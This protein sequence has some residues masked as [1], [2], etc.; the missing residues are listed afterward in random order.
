MDDTWRANL[1]F[2]GLWCVYCDCGIDATTAEGVREMKHY[3]RAVCPE[4]T[5]MIEQTARIGVR[6]VEYDAATGRFFLSLRNRTYATRHEVPEHVA[7]RHFTF[8]LNERYS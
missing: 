6:R 2:P 5:T 7:Y 4:Y 8:L 3:H 1:G